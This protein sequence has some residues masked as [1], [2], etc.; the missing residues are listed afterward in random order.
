MKRILLTALAVLSAGLLDNPAS[1][2][3]PISA[4]ASGLPVS[5]S[6]DVSVNQVYIVRRRRRRYRTVRTVWVDGFG[7]SHVRY[8]RVWY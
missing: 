4:P 1:A 6:Q 8:K 5:L 2:A 3:E 7:V